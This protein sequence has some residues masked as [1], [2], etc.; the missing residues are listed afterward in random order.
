ML[1][2]DDYYDHIHD[3]KILIKHHLEDVMVV[4]R[5]D[6]SFRSHSFSY[7]SFAARVEGQEAGRKYKREL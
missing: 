5:K 1:E 3:Q 2:E 7:E 4:N 6:G